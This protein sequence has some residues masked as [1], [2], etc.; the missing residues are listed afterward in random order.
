MSINV[1]MYFLQLCRIYVCLLSICLFALYIS[2]FELA[3]DEITTH[4]HLP[5]SWRVCV[6]VVIVLSRAYSQT[7]PSQ[8]TLCAHNHLRYHDFGCSQQKADIV[9]SLSLWYM[10]RIH[11]D[12]HT[13]TNIIHSHRITGKRKQ[14]FFLLLLS[15]VL[16]NTMLA[17]LSHQFVWI[18]SWWQF[19]PE[20]SSYYY[21]YIHIIRT[22]HPHTE[23]ERE[24]DS[25]IHT[26]TAAARIL[27][28]IHSQ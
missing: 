13:N 22:T 6:C 11:T 18:D 5:H 12:T 21:V 16:Y 8:S 27:F 17:V 10:H 28:T 14:I 4:T 24:K 3:H 2:P 23:R 25:H 7:N 1:C 26:H 9:L 20:A 19:G 15:V